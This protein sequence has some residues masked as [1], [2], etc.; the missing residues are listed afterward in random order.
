MTLAP[1]CF[2]AK[3]LLWLLAI[4]AVAA[5]I[6]GCVGSSR[7]LALLHFLFQAYLVGGCPSY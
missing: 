6:G 4:S 1:V 5:C 2:L 3:R 7:G